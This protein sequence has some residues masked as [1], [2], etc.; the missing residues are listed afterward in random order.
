M[1]LSWRKESWG[2][3]AMTFSQSSVSGGGANVSFLFTLSVVSLCD[4]DGHS[5][6]CIE[7]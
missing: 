1:A 2:A 7:E 6:R 4:E 5:G 3:E